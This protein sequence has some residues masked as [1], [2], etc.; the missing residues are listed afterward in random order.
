MTMDGLFF[1]DTSEQ[2]CPH[3]GNQHASVT[4]KEH[5]RIEIRK[6]GK[7][8]MRFETSANVPTIV[9]DVC[10]CETPLTDVD[11]V[12]EFLDGK[13]Q[14]EKKIFDTKRQL[15]RQLKKARARIIT[16]AVSSLLFSPI[17]LMGVDALRQWNLP[18]LAF[19]FFFGVIPI[20]ANLWGIWHSCSAL[21][22][23]SLT[24]LERC[25]SVEAP[26]A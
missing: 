18:L 7:E 19:S 11:A 5:R 8:V 15:T 12:H 4:P 1:L 14:S 10:H 24:F 2:V 21:L 6:E 13:L 25:Q 16:S 9:C 17:L 26:E 20:A 23:S 22:I 3:C